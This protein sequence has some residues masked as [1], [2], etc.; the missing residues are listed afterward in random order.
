M[1]IVTLTRHLMINLSYTSSSSS[2]SFTG[3]FDFSKFISFC[4]TLF[5]R[6]IDS[7]INQQN[8]LKIQWKLE[9]KKM[10]IEMKTIFQH[11]L[12]YLFKKKSFCAECFE[13]VL[14]DNI[15][16]HVELSKF[17]LEQTL[18]RFPFPICQHNLK[19]NILSI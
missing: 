8:K 2:C 10:V 6:N 19:S 7:S 9:I 13:I 5:S 11:F 1:Y 17:W 3:L 15:K 14:N 18:L 12:L 16:I 4:E